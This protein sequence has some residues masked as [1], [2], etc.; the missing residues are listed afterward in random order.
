MVAVDGQSATNTAAQ[1][2]GQGPLPIKRALNTHPGIETPEPPDA[3]QSVRRV[4]LGHLPDVTVSQNGGYLKSIWK[5]PS[6]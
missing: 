3:E 5:K 1:K 6:S 4:P 2:A